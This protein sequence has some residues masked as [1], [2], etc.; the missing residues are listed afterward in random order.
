MRK[1]IILTLLTLIGCKK[2]E[3]VK[4]DDITGADQQIVDGNK[5]ITNIHPDT[6]GNTD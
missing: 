2:E 5:N 6:K 4:A 1:T 3:K